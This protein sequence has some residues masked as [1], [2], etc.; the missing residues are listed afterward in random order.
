VLAAAAIGFFLFVPTLKL[1]GKLATYNVST[2]IP[3]ADSIRLEDDE[4]RFLAGVGDECPPATCTIVS[5]G[6]SRE[7][8]DHE[9]W[10]VSRWYARD[11]RVVRPNDLNHEAPPGATVYWIGGQIPAAV[12]RVGRPIPAAGR[13]RAYVTQGEQTPR[14]EALLELR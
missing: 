5:L 9:P 14:L 1:P 11:A 2:F 10:S 3:T 8:W 6:T 12:P 4:A 7:L 13:W